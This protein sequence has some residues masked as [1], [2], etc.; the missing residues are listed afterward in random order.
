MVS[1]EEGLLR[2]CQI[3]ECFCLV[4]IPGCRNIPGYEGEIFEGV[5][6]P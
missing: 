2:A 3:Q 5:V 4:C 6:V 1:L